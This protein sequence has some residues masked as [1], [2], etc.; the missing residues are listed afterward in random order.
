MAYIEPG[1]YSKK[2]LAGNSM[3]GVGNLIIGIVGETLGEEKSLALLVSRTADIKDIL[4]KDVIDI[5][6]VYQIANAI[7]IPFKKDIDYSFNNTSGLDE[8]VWNEV[9]VIPAMVQTVVCIDSSG[10]II[11]EGNFSICR[12]GVQSI[13]DTGQTTV[14]W[15]SFNL[16][17]ETAAVE[18]TWVSNGSVKTN[19]CRDIDNIQVVV[20]LS[21]IGKGIT[22]V[23]FTKADFTAVGTAIPAATNCVNKPDEAETYTVNLLYKSFDLAYNKPVY[24]YTEKDVWSAHG[25]TSPLGIA[26]SLAFANG[27]AQLLLV[28]S[29]SDTIAH[30]STALNT[31]KN[32]QCDV[33]ICLNS[34]M[35]VKLLSF[36]EYESSY[37]IKNEMCAMV[38]APINSIVGDK[39]TANSIIYNARQFSNKRVTYVGNW[40]MINGV[41]YDGNYLACAIA[42]KRCG[43]QDTAKSLTREIIVGVEQLGLTLS[44]VE[45]NFLA[46]NGVLVVYGSGGFN[47]IRHDIT[48]DT[49]VLENSEN[50]V[51]YTDDMLIKGLRSVLEVYIGKKINNGLITSIGMT[52]Q[53]YLDYFK[54]S[55]YIS[56]YTNLKVGQDVSKLT[57]VLVYFKYQPIYPCN[58]IE[59]RYGFDIV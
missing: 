12:V 50:S 51:V 54:D 48:T 8:I 15:K 45:M 36:I 20:T 43:V 19:I 57:R 40:G 13:N 7:A 3:V 6:S 30:F 26:S 39:Q 4:M 47:K 1:V 17:N 44:R 21:P 34:L 46:D 2:D 24:Y 37:A 58:E 49:Q 52:V 27:A 38:G 5:V 25:R 14:N 28:G 18:I 33:V 23:R 22:F 9:P 31:L 53:K 29:E 35:G 32:M 56:S 41:E 11:K 10:N 55:V 42:G 59:V 16:Y